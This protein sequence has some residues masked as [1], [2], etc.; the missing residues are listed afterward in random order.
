MEAIKN[1]N[2]YAFEYASSK[3]KDDSEVVLL[4][5]ELSKSCGKALIRFA[6]KRIRSN[7]DVIKKAYEINPKYFK[8]AGP[9]LQD[10]IL[11]IFELSQINLSIL[12]YKFPNNDALLKAL[13]KEPSIYIHLPEEYRE[14][15]IFIV[16]A[17][18]GD[19]SLINSIPEELMND[20]NFLCMLEELQPDIRKYL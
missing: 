5:L 3:L 4:A 12:E 10:N 11:F 7:R 9:D 2:G 20:E 13:K 16:T 1:S 14:E 8:Y 17:L 18:K 6:S 19:P 15:E